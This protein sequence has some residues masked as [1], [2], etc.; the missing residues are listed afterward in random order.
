MNCVAYILPAYIKL[1][2]VHFLAQRLLAPEVG[3]AGVC[4]QQFLQKVYLIPVSLLLRAQQ[5]C[6][7]LV[8]N[9]GRLLEYC[10]PAN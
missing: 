2:G 7:I 10:A 9:T 1:Y 3:S 5:K 6:G 4:A 8:K